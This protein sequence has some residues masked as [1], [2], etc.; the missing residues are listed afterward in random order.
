MKLWIIYKNGISFS[1]VIAEMLQDL[2]E[3]YIDVDVGKV[4]NI[5]PA[6]LREE[7]LDYLIIGDIIS[8]EIP[9]IELQN[10]LVKFWELSREK[11]I[12]LKAI[13]GFYVKLAEIKVE[14]FWVEQLYD[15]V[16]PNL[17]YPPILRL[18][19]DKV[20]LGLENDALDLIKEYSNDFIEFIINNNTKKKLR[21]RGKL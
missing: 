5:D 8:K 12:D 16:K 18:K 17:I 19:L 10:W 7:K 3:D 2:W 14:P 9:S 4:K 6:F 20:G 15:K 13:S 21:H 1:K 11:N